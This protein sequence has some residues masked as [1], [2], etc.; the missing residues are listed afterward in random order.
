MSM[1]VSVNVIKFHY[2]AELSVKDGSKAEAGQI[3]ANW[4]PHSHPVITEVAGH[5]KFV[6]LIEGITMNRQTDELT[7]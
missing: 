5:I 3:V 4:D 2:G 6:D 7:G 1:V